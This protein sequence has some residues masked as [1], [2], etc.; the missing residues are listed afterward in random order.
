MISALV[1][2]DVVI[3]EVMTLQDRETVTDTSGSLGSRHRERIS[4]SNGH[5]TRDVATRLPLTPMA[6]ETRAETPSIGR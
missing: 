5:H 4:E 1:L 3:P 2:R 6:R